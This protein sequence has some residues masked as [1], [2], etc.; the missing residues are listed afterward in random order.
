MSGSCSTGPGVA[1]TAAEATSFPDDDSK[2]GAAMPVYQFAV[3]WNEDQASDARW[4]Y[5]EA[6]EAARHYAK[7]LAK[8]S[9][10]TGFYPY[11][12]RSRVEVRDGTGSVLFSIPFREVTPWQAKARPALGL[13]RAKRT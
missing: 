13:T 1:P 9:V 4:T 12:S 7:L 6:V 5:L 3:R 8:E 2:R 11:S 10:S